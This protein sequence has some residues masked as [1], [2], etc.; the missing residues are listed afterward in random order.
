MYEKSGDA[1]IRMQ[2][3]LT[4]IPKT[5][6]LYNCHVCASHVIIRPVQLIVLGR[7]KVKWL[8]ATTPRSLSFFSLL[9][10]RFQQLQSLSTRTSPSQHTRFLC[11]VGLGHTSS[12]LRPRDLPASCPVPSFTFTLK[13]RLRAFFFLQRS[14]PFD[15]HDSHSHSHS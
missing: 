5:T 9:F 10:R 15:H 12:R 2:S 11:C 6:K 3:R 14:L 1:G 13:R 8:A 7:H 4:G